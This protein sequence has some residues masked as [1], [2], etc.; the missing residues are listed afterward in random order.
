[1]VATPAGELDFQTYY[2]GRH[3]SDTVTGLRYDGAGT[4][5][6]GPGVIEALT[7]ARA[8]LIAPSNP[9]ISI[10][11]ILAVPG[12]REALQ[13]ARAMRRGQPDRG[14]CGPARACCRHDAITRA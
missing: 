3:H 2:V 5:R 8:I 6:P 14:G 4:A 10:E 13:V 7:D 12:V 11:P 9:L 1:M